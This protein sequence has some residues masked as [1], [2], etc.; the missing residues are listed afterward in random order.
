MIEKIFVSEAR[1]K[2]L[3][4]LI[5]SDEE[6]LHI[7]E[8]TRRIKTE[9]NAV[10][11]ELENL[12]SIKL[13]SKVPRGNRVFYAINREHTLFPELLGMIGKEY[14]LGK[15]LLNSYKKL[16]EIKFISLRRGFIEGIKSKNKEVDLLIVGKVDI[17]KAEKLVS[18]EEERTKLDINFSV[19]DLEE[20]SYRKERKDP[21]VMGILLTP[22]VML[23]GSEEDLVK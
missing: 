20:L 2:L 23:V 11:R 4:E 8:L 18:E 21:F 7:R 15:K 22:K 14:G 17:D 12:E 1:V 5:L 16:G 13:V 9:V 3:K 6:D 10:R 19:L